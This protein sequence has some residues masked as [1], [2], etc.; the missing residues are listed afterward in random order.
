MEKQSFFTV[1]KEELEGRHARLTVEF[2]EN[3]IRERLNRTAKELAKRVRLPGYRPGKAP[4]RAV[5][6][7]LGEEA[8]REKLAE[9]LA[10]EVYFDALKEAGIEPFD[11]GEIES[12][13]LKPMKFVFTVPLAPVV[14]LDD[15][16]KSVRIEEEE[17]KVDDEMVDKALEGLQEES[18]QW[19]PT[20]EEAA[21]PGDK[22]TIDLKVSADGKEM[23]DEEEL[24]FVLEEGGVF[25]QEFVDEVVGMKVGE[26]KEFKIDYP[27]DA[28]VPWAGKEATFT[29]EL[30][31]V[32]RK[33]VPELDDEFAKEMGDFEDLEELKQRI[34]QSFEEEL[35]T[36]AKNQFVEKALD[37]LLEHAEMEYPEEM[38]EKE[39][40]LLVEN[41]KK[42]ISRMGWDWNSFLRI[43]GKDEA[44]FRE[45]LREEAKRAVEERLALKELAKAEN[46]E[47]SEEDVNDKIKTMLAS[48]PDSKDTKE[49]YENE[50][51]REAVRGELLIEKAYDKWLEMVSGKPAEEETTEEATEEETEPETT[52]EEN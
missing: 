44:S 29:V 31:S 18:A 25:R 41:R 26:T 4:A 34:R 20:E 48:I 27:E 46:I 5:L 51:F 33:E 11:M 3:Q 17:V 22:I 24:E 1:Q 49:L 2:D 32:K 45:S 50:D 47:V 38:I 19:V 21:R 30:L 15:G 16:Y 42:E 12:V 35:S 52:E 23:L 37:A 13:E 9:Q 10:E 14:K 40:N 8:V 28:K 39:L 36:Q 6:R 43:S 7:Y